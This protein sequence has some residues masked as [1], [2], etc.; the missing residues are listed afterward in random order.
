MG[1]ICICLWCIPQFL[2]SR[3]CS[4]CWQLTP[5]VLCLFVFICAFVCD[6]YLFVWHEMCLSLCVCLSSWDVFVRICLFVMIQHPQILDSMASHCSDCW[7]LTPAPLCLSIQ[8]LPG[9]C[10]LQSRYFEIFQEMT[11]WFQKASAACNQD[12]LKYFKIFQEMWWWFQK[13][14]AGSDQAILKYFK[15]WDDDFKRPL[16]AAIKIFHK[17]GRNGARKQS[18]IYVD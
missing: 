16:Q 8:A 7:Q 1:M 4:Y 18:E 12:I 11:W 2:V 6:V 10:S 15:R 14:S 5:A 3:K 17:K 13:A 9:L